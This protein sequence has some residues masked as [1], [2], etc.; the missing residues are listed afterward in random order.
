MS[1]DGVL[2]YV[3]TSTDTPAIAKAF[4][5]LREFQTRR[6]EQ[7]E[8][9][10]RQIEALESESKQRWEGLWESMKAG[11]KVPSDYR[12]KDYN[13]S[14]NGPGHSQIFINKTDGKD[15]VFAAIMKKMLE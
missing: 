1:D 13:I 4:E 10:K 6:E 9:L 8:F 11:G 3:C 7:G 12:Y 2:T 5:E 15:G 14:L